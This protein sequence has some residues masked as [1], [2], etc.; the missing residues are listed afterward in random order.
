[1]LRRPVINKVAFKTDAPNFRLPTPL[2]IQTRAA[3]Q[4]SRRVTRSAAPRVV[5]AGVLPLPPHAPFLSPPPTRPS[6]R[7]PFRVHITLRSPVTSLPLISPTSPGR[8]VTGLAFAISGH[9]PARTYVTSAGG[10]AAA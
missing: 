6:W 7:V 2:Q 3:R 8:P 10:S 5:A 9:V 1:M 4:P